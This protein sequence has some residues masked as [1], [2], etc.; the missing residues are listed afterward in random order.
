MDSLSTPKE[1]APPMIPKKSPSPA[2][3]NGKRMSVPN[4]QPNTTLIQLESALLSVINADFGTKPPENALIATLDTLL[5]TELASSIQKLQ[6]LPMWNLIL[7]ATNGELMDAN[8]A[9]IEPILMLM[10]SAK[11]LIISVGLGIT[12]MDVVSVAIQDMT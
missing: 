8:L 10:E 3:A 9:P 2:A 7:S 12:L 6:D 5:I 4:V 11:K 1:L